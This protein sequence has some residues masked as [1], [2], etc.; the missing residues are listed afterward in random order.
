MTRV[1]FACANGD[2]RSQMAAAWFNQIAATER[3]RAISA[4]RRVGAC[5]YP[6]E[7][8]Q[9]MQ[10]VGVDFLPVLPHRLSGPLAAGAQHLVTMGPAEDYPFFAGVK[11]EDWSVEDP[12]GK[13]IERVR[14]IRDEIRGRV[15]KMIEVNGW[16]RLEE[17]RTG[18]RG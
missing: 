5:G 12:R 15:E 18:T 14:Q 10:E 16:G 4:A 8:A 1:I 6:E 7:V 17:T 3:V 13:P 11:I 9:V 2:G